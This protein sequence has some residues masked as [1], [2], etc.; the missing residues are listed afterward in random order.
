LRQFGYPSGQEAGGRL[1]RRAS[2]APGAWLRVS[3][4]R[5]PPAHRKGL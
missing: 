5:H 4:A 2:G 1:P 3:G